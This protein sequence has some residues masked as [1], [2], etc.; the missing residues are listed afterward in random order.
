MCIKYD[1]KFTTLPVRP[2]PP[3]VPV[4]SAAAPPTPPPPR[5]RP[6]S[7]V[8]SPPSLI[9]R[10]HGTLGYYAPQPPSRPPRPPPFTADTRTETPCDRFFF[11]NFLSQSPRNSISSG[12]GRNERLTTTF[13]R[14]FKKQ[15]LLRVVGFVQKLRSDTSC[16]DRKP[17]SRRYFFWGG[18][19]NV[20][21]STLKSF[22]LT[23]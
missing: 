16:V 21:F 5:D 4:I 2:R 1:D 9:P 20:L 17:S 23:P 7:F 12:S 10:A 15:T 19:G 11:F 3:A 14:V 22:F 6:T 13:V 18:G 8:P